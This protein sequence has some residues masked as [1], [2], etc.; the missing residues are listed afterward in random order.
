MRASETPPGKGDR[1][2]LNRSSSARAD[3]REG[4]SPGGEQDPS[5]GEAASQ[6]EEGS[7]GGGG[8]E[9]A[10]WDRVLELYW[11]GS[12]KKARVLAARCAMRERTFATLRRSE[13][14]YVFDPDKMTYREEGA[15]VLRELLAERLG[16]YHTTYEVGQI[17]AKIEARTYVRE[18]GVA[19]AIPLRNGDLSVDPPQLL[20]FDPERRY[21]V[22]TLAQWNQSA[23]CPKF[24]RLL[25]KVVPTRQERRLL[26]EYAG[27]CL[28]HWRRPWRRVLL[29][30]GLEGNGVGLVMRAVASIIPWIAQVSPERLAHFSEKSSRLR[31]PWVNMV[32]GVSPEALAEIPILQDF[33]AGGPLYAD[34]TQIRAAKQSNQQTQRATKHVYGVRELPALPVGEVFFRRV[35]LVRFPK[36]LSASDRP[37]FK[38]LLSEERDGILRWAV[39][40]LQR[41]LE[42]GGF[43]SGRGAETTRERW[44]A[45]SGPIGRFKAGIL[46]VTGDP[47]DVVDKRAVYNAYRE[48]CKDEGI[49]ADTI[50]QFTRTLT[51]G[52]RI[53]SA[54]RVPQP[55][56]D[57]VRC[58]V[59]VRPRE[60]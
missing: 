44:Q 16:P 37:N 17:R 43:P 60:R 15:Q 1:D 21:V 29:L 28:M 2:F 39:D 20:D 35:L 45:F 10:T 47:Q 27:Y 46:E 57:Q 3:T 13:D 50:D 25:R 54:K 4:P 12:K 41:V 30:T 58:Y 48:F 36:Q 19:E 52:P 5:A 14:L 56:G 55:D 22:R 31:G 26:Q 8:E 7:G 24:R 34:R 18:F 32:N 53:E 51:E 59:G 6:V 38:R 9:P 33:A 40:G 42:S 11:E 23:E 49:L